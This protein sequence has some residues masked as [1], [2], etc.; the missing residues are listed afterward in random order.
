[1]TLSTAA[2]SDC[3]YESELGE[4]GTCCVSLHYGIYVSHWEFGSAV[5]PVRLIL[6]HRD[7]THTQNLFP[8]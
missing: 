2:N 4:S 8:N 3:F 5:Q 1:M 6:L 7:Y